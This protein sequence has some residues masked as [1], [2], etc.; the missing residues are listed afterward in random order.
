MAK[1]GGM[2]NP[3]ELLSVAQTAEMLS[4]SRRAVL[5]RIAAGTIAAQKVGT[6]RTSSYVVARAEVE[7]VLAERAA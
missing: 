6:G 3:T 4:L 2:P 5:H 7:R 1:L